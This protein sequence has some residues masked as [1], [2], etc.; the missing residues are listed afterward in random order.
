MLAYLSKRMLLLLEAIALKDLRIHVNECISRIKQ[1][2][3]NCQ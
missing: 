1:N 3:K 2:G